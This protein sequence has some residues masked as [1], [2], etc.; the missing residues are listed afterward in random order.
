MPDARRISTTAEFMQLEPLWRQLS[1]SSPE[2]SIFSSWDWQTQWWEHY[3][4]K[5]SLSV[6]VLNDKG[7]D[8]AI[9]P[10]YIKERRALKLSSVR[11]LRMLGTGGDTSPDYLGLISAKALSDDAYNALCQ[12]IMETHDWDVLVFTDLREDDALMRALS[13]RFKQ[14]GGHC[15]QTPCAEIRYITMPT[16]FDDYL[17]SLSSNQR[18]QVRRRRRRA[19]EAGPFT[20]LRWPE[21]KAIDEAF[22]DMVRLHQLRRADLD[23]AGSFN[24]EAYLS[25]HRSVMTALQERGNLRLYCMYLKGEMVAIEY[26]YKWNRRIFSFQCGFDPHYSEFRPGQLLLNYSIEDAITEGIVE[27]DLLKGDYA[28]KESVAK[29][30]RH[31]WSI[32]GYRTSGRGRL[33]AFGD[34]IA[35]LK[36][37]F[38]SA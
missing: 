32:N 30:T 4:K 8:I 3:G 5:H 36:D 38:R 23:E 26:S 25:F 13:T 24:T 37:R 34:D 22:D 10:L 7:E 6:W 18:K 15:G 14:Q 11:E 33:A 17:A 9:L 29:T 27:Y 31:T 19:E 20:F 28:Y 35:Q 1:E 16:T 2:C 21:D 12:A